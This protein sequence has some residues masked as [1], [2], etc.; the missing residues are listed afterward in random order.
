[1]LD[2]HINYW[3][4]QLRGATAL[5]LPTDRP[6]SAVQSYRGASHMFSLPANLSEPLT[7]LSRQ[8]GV[9][10]FMTLLLPVQTQL[11][12][13]FARFSSG[14]EEHRFAKTHVPVQLAR[15]GDEQL[16]S[17]SQAKR[18]LNRFERFDEAML[19]FEGVRT[20]GQAF[21]DEIF[22]VFA[23]KYPNVQLRV[24]NDNPQIRGMIR[25]AQAAKAEQERARSA[26]PG[27]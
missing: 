5:E 6:R 8:E 1:M 26:E 10:I 12:D 14:P 21:A 2:N 22:R 27:K 25:R 13:V 24:I 7:T 17:R 18:V 15:Y 16:I 19:D 20:V 11:E 4:K 3:K 9:S 23:S